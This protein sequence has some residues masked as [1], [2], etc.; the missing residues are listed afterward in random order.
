MTEGS[1]NVFVVTGGQRGAGAQENRREG[2]EGWKERGK[3][4]VQL[5]RWRQAGEIEKNIAMLHNILQ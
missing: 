3:E 5:P 1:E 2:Y 4:A